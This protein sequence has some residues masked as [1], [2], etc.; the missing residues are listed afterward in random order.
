M[1]ALLLAALLSA[2]GGLDVELLDAGT[3]LPT[4]MACM[5]PADAVTLDLGLRSAERD[6]DAYKGWVMVVT[7]I[8]VV[9]TVAVG[10]LAA[11]LATKR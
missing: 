2:D 4:Q 9:A 8:A 1:K 5:P 11:G 7:P 6:R 3:V 10:V